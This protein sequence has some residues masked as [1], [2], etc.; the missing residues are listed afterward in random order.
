MSNQLRE[1]HLKLVGSEYNPTGLILE[2]ENNKKKIE[3]YREEMKALIELVDEKFEKKT[4]I[5]DGIIDKFKLL[6][7]IGAFLASVISLKFLIDLG[8]W[9]N[10]HIL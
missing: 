8:K 9:I 4:S 6:F 3:D 10:T 2:T 1:I 5:Y 7:K